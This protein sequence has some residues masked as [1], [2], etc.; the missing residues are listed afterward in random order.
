MTEWAHDERQRP[1]D[2]LAKIIAEHASSND[3]RRVDG[4]DQ[5]LDATFYVDLEGIGKLSDLL[6]HLQAGC[7]GATVTVI[8]QN[9]MP[10]V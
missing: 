7:P 2:E 6:A 1:L 8:D 3:L 10:S 5:H 4:S 9:R